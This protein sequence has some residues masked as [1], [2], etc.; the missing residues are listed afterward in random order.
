MTISLAGQT[1]AFL[2]SC[3]LGAALC[4]L[5]DVFRALR[6]FFMFGRA[7]TAVFD[8][9]YFFLAAI[10]TFAFF[11]AISRGEIRGY[12]CFGELIGWLLYY[13][14]IGSWSFRLQNGVFRFLRRTVRKIALPFRRFSQKLS[15]CAASQR[16]DKKKQEK[17]RKKRKKRSDSAPKALATGRKN[18]V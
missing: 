8:L 10:F 5:Y 12:L 4:V 2:Y 14:T 16:A 18:S 6:V 7:L 1:I 15:A 9:L 3:A 17:G 11:M 13:E